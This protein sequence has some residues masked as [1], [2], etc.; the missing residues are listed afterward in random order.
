MQKNVSIVMGS[1]V[2]A[3]LTAFAFALPSHVF[4]QLPPDC[5]IG[6]NYIVCPFSSA[7]SVTSGAASV[8]V[9]APGLVLSVTSGAASVKVGAAG[10]S[11]PPPPD[12]YPIDKIGCACYADRR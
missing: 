6:P 3:I 12:C 5:I 10:I 8:K 9:G 2:A 11:C 4:A 1:V 7:L